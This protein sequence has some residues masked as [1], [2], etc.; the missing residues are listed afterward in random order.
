MTWQP[1]RLLHRSAL[2]PRRLGVERLEDRLTP[3]VLPSGF[4]ETAIATGLAA[5]TAME[6]APDGRIFVAEQGGNLRVIDNT[7][8]LLATPF[9]TLTV[10]SQGERGL[11]GVTLDPSFTTNHFLYVY[12]TATAPVVHNRISRFTANGNVAVTGSEVDL[13]DLDPLSTATNHNGGALHFGTDGKLYVGVGENGNGSNAQTLSNLLGKMLRINPDGSIPTDNPFFN[14]ATGNNRAIWA[15]G[16]RNPYTFAV[17]PGTGRIFINDVGANSWEEID[18]GIGGSNYGWPFSE[19]FRKPTDTQ[20]TIGTY[21]DPLFA[22]DHSNGTKAIVGGSFYNP[23]TTQFPASY[24]GD[25]FFSDFVAGFVKTFNPANGAVADFATGL[26]SPVDLDVASDGSLYYLQRG[27]GGNTGAVFQIQ[28]NSVANQNFVTH[29]YEDLLGREPDSSGLNGWVGQLNAGMS[30]FQVTQSIEA[31]AEWRDHEVS[32]LYQSL[33]HRQ[34]DPQG[35]GAFTQY[36]ANGGTL[37]FARGALL[38]S[39]EYFSLHGSS[40]DGFVSALYQDVLGRAADPNGKANWLQQ[41]MNGMSR[42]DVAL[43][44]LFSSEARQV[45][46]AGFYL[47]F[48]KRQADQG[49][50]AAFENQLLQGVR[51]QVVIAEIIASDE[52]FARA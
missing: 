44:V 20:T 29:V 32:G 16:L 35:L 15:L 9:V 28:F 25:Y 40:N 6:L 27:T 7:G 13:L 33:L 42:L 14:T 22:Y 3:A 12:Y 5:P 34:P 2:A 21:R 38:A 45:Q 11:I 52:Y 10:D 36:L 23:A 39:G 31:S 26:A 46:V 24:V 19:G 48:L 17:Q 1:F 50:L 41:M 30:R 43:H 47:S 4:G 51:E 37:D 18:D 49:G 8:H